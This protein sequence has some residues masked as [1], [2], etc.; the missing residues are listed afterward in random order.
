VGFADATVALVLEL[1]TGRSVRR[2]PVGGRLIATNHF[3]SR[4]LRRRAVQCKRYDSL[5]ALARRAGPTMTVKQMTDALHTNRIPEM[6]LQAAVFEPAAMRVHL[7]I[8]KVPASAGPFVELDLA[9]L[10]ARPPDDP[11]GSRAAAP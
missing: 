10:F 3:R 9:E 4:A 6:N 8:N 2:D 7:S 1:G 5:G 11:P